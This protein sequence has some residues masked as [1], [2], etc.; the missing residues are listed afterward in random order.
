M[1]ASINSMPC[2]PVPAFPWPHAGHRN[3]STTFP[4]RKNRRSLRCG[5]RLQADYCVHLEHDADVEQ[6]WALP[7]AFT[8]T[9]ASDK[10]RYTPHF[11]IAN[12]DGGGCY[13]EVQTSFAQLPAQRMETRLAFATLCREQGWRFHCVTDPDVHGPTF[14]TLQKLYLRSLATSA[15]ELAACLQRLPELCWPAT[16]REVLNSHPAPPSLAALCSCLFLGHLQADLS[17]AL[18]LNL[19]IRGPTRESEGG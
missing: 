11:L 13:C 8:W 5:T 3:F 15:D 19:M 1:L 4:S 2:D 10:H 7:H 6:Y 14:A 12:R 18:D 9:T 16:F 17:Q